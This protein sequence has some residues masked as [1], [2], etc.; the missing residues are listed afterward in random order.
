MRDR[1]ADSCSCQQILTTNQPGTQDSHGCPFRHF[2]PDN[3]ATFLV[4]SYP[5]LDRSSAEMRDILDSVKNSHYHVAC[6]RVFEVTHGLKKGDG[7]GK[8]GETVSHPNRYTERSREIE[9]DRL[10]LVKK[11]EGDED[12]VMAE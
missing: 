3:L 7:L 2:S 1:S 11:D 10:G 8:D 9:A 12:V 6:T 4:S 5:T